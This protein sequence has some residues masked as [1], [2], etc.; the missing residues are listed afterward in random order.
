MSVGI[1]ILYNSERNIKLDHSEFVMGPLSRGS[2]FNVI[3][4]GINKGLQQFGWLVG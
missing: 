2:T 3:A 1:Y 4:E